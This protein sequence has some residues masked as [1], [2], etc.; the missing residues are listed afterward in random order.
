MDRG[1]IHCAVEWHVDFTTWL[2]SHELWDD[3]VSI[4]FF[5][6]LNFKLLGIR[7]LILKSSTDL[8]GKLV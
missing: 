3:S 8:A 7:V 1:E 2:D 4:I 6:M 5:C